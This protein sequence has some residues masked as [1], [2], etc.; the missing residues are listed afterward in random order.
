MSASHND[1]GANNK[2]IP[3]SYELLV[4]WPRPRLAAAATYIGQNR[5]SGKTSSPSLP[6]SMN[7]NGGNN[8]QIGQQ[9]ME[10]DN[11]RNLNQLINMGKF[12]QPE[13]NHNRDQ[14]QH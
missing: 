3:I 4:E 11:G 14:H 5:I 10:L 8:A 7:L 13:N 1:G 12:N 6:Y 2:Y 9:F